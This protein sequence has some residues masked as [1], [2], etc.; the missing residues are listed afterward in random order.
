MNTLDASHSIQRKIRDKSY[1][2]ENYA[3]EDREE[4]NRT[5]RE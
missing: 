2:D 1:W 3:R 4:W 5:V